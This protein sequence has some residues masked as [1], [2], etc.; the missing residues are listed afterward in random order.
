[1]N[2]PS[3]QEIVDKLVS[4]IES[5]RVFPRGFCFVRYIGMEPVTVAEVLGSDLLI[6][7]ARIQ[8]TPG[9]ITQIGDAVKRRTDLR[10]REAISKFMSL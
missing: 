9:Q 8:L 4:L 2:N 10:S 6:D 7:S 1:M 5:E 3:P